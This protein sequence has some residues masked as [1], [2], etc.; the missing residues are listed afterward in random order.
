MKKVTAKKS[1]SVNI[2]NIPNDD[3]KENIHKVR[4]KIEDI[5]LEREQKKLWDL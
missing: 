3:R 2:E 4:K 1:K 5:L